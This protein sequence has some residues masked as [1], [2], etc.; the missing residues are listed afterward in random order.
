M[1]CTFLF[2]SYAR[3]SVF[4]TR[5][6]QKSSRR[7]VVE[8]ARANKPGLFSELF[9]ARPTEQVIFLVYKHV[10]SL[11]LSLDDTSRVSVVRNYLH[12]SPDS[13][14]DPPIGFDFEPLLQGS[15]Q[16]VNNNDYDGIKETGS[17][18]TNINAMIHK[19]EPGFAQDPIW[20]VS[21]TTKSSHLC[22]LSYYLFLCLGFDPQ[23]FS[24]VINNILSS[25][26]LA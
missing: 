14:I 11:R 15:G 4:E 1:I 5:G 8:E 18:Q 6:G 19:A 26:H 25:H 16:V 3:Q 7:H 24:P 17:R 2:L 9:T 20:L 10:L 13:R 12:L 22:L 23:T 21:L